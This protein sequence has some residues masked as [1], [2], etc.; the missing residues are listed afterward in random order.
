MANDLKRLQQVLGWRDP[1]SPAFGST[2]AEEAAADD[3]PGAQPLTGAQLDELRDLL[4]SDPVGI[5]R[6]LSRV[7]DLDTTADAEAVRLTEQLIAEL[8]RAYDDPGAVADELEAAFSKRVELPPDFTFPGYNPTE[9]PIEPGL[10]KFETRADM[11]GYA[12]LSGAWFH[13]G[14]LELAPWRRHDEV[15]SRFTY[16]VRPGEEPTP[17]KPLDVV[18]FAD[19]GNGLYPARYMAKQFADLAAPYAIHLGDVYYAGTRLEVDEHL[20]QPLWPTFD[21]T[22]VFSVVGNHEMYSRGAPWLAFTDEKRRQFPARQRQQG[23]YFRIVTERFQIVALDTEWA[24]HGRLDPSQREIGR[25]WLREGRNDRTTILLTSN[26]PHTWGSTKKSALYD[27]IKPL[28]DEGLVD[29]WFWGNVH[30][31]ALYEPT[32]ELPFVGSC[33]GHGGYPYYTIA[34][35]KPSVAPLRWAETAHRFDPW[36]IRRDVGNNG[37]CRMR[38]RHDG[39]LDLEYVDWM[40]RVRHRAHVDARDGHPRLT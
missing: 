40:G 28:L 11:L 39:T 3:D 7:V 23:P 2:G 12:V 24:G 6:G 9:I 18:L 38:L 13:I 36:P 8:H 1:S 30:H 21:K 20:W 29:L 35:G 17:D 4:A 25:Q 31:G 27:D 26:H 34:A 10:T 37:F 32:P 5:A 19:F 16:P 33:L 15:A 14:T 22:E